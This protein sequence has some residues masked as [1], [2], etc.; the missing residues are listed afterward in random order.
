MGK[1]ET[2]TPLG[3]AAERLRT[4][5]LDADEG[6]FIGSEDALIS[7]LGCSRSTVRQ[8]ARLLEREGLP[9]K[10]HDFGARGVSSLESA[11][12]GGMAH[13]VNF[14]GTDTLTGPGPAVL[15]AA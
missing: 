2:R 10:L 15:A 7:Q 1:I 4:I 8:V 3:V 9:F 13:L 12:L 14:R 11:M 6:A 5:V